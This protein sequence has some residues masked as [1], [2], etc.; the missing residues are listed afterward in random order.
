MSPLGGFKN[1]LVSKTDNFLASHT[2]MSSA[3]NPPIQG[4]PAVPPSLNAGDYEMHEKRSTADVPPCTLPYYTP[5]LGL[6]ARLSQIWLNKW[7]ILL[8]LIICRLLLATKD[9][10]TGIENA[11]DQ[12]LSSCT[13]VENVGSAMASMPHYL[14]DG[15]NALAADGVTKAVNG[16]MDMLTLTVTGVEEMVVFWINMLTS[17]YLC[18]I[19]FAIAGSLHAVIDVIQ[20]VGDFMNKSIGTITG[21]MASDLNSFT[22]S[23]NSFLSA[24][25]T[26]GGIFGSSKTPPT[27][28]LTSQINSLTHI[29]VDPT[30]M[31]AG[32]TKLN[33]SI[34][35]FNQVQNLTNNALRVPFEEIKKLI[36]ESIVAYKFD[37][38]VFPVAQKQALTFCSDNSSIN[39]FFDGLLKTVLKVRTIVVVIVALLAVAVCVPITYREI[40]RWRTMRQRSVLLQKHAFDP[41]D[42]INIASRPLSTGFGIK[43]ASK[44]KSTKSQILV[45]WFCAYITTIPA[46]FVLALG[47]AG[48]FSCI[49]QYIILKVIVKEIPTL[50]NEV[51]DFAGVVVTAL[52]NASTAWAVG[53][54]GVINDTN[55]KI[56]RE[57]FGWVN[58]STT[59]LNNTL[60]TFS[61]EMVSVLN[62]TFGG[63]ILY[64]PV[65]EVVNCVI[66]LK[67]A[68][69]EKGLTWV[70]DNAHVAFPQFNSDVFS[71]GAVASIASNSSSTDSFLSSPGDVASDSITSAIVKMSNKLAEQIK[72]EAIISAALVGIWVLVVLIALARVLYASLLRDKTRAEGGPVGYTGDHR[73]SMSPRSPNRGQ[74]DPAQFPRFGSEVYHTDSHDDGA[75]AAGGLSDEGKVGVV[76]RNRVE[77]SRVAHGHE[78]TSSYGYLADEKRG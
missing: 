44:F 33:S 66:G 62:A 56:N 12:A 35:N 5:Y 54:N 77:D 34:P 39:D 10:N 13:S 38:S 70:H 71:L 46:L 75:W 64:D 59:A 74:G 31:D 42:V 32:L 26:V 53:A 25:T 28:N 61:D 2:E 15:V 43:L 36:N 41:M 57:V 50:A 19:T 9:I 27:I 49:S 20:E 47:V 52:N 65:M 51:G 23:L 29:T 76:G 30:S 1:F 14:S 60:N 45:R 40:R 21:E 22:Q 17:T 58:T 48:L 16:L 73:G 8:L 18:L 72:T 63:T 11:K 4:F 24:I 55:L 3:R 7:T 67:I 37:K 68:G 78:R 69:I 6:R